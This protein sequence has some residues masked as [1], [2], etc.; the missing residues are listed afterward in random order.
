MADRR[1]NYQPVSA[2]FSGREFIPAVGSRD[3]G[4]GCRRNAVS[5][6][7]RCK[8]IAGYVEERNRGTA[9]GQIADGVVDN[10][11][12]INQ[13][14]GHDVNLTAANNSGAE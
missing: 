3:H 10:A 1:R 9:D 14:L 4:V 7:Y 11:E 8:R 13:Q 12:R 5:A 6:K 2:R